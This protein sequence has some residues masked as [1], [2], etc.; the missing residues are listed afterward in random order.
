VPRQ[1]RRYPDGR[2]PAIPL[3]GAERREDWRGETYAVRPVPG[4]S[5]TKPYRCPGCDQLVAIG[6]PH[7]VVWRADDLGAENRRHWHT[8]CWAARH[9]RGPR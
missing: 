5:A 7:V 9:R 8:A 6:T 3:G 1:N 2:R 4:M